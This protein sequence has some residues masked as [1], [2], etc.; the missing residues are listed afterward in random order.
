MHS[1]AN[2]HPGPLPPDT[3][4]GPTPQVDKWFSGITRDKPLGPLVHFMG[5]ALDLRGPA[6]LS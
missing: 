2:I 4:Y 5:T 3:H 6:L 1:L